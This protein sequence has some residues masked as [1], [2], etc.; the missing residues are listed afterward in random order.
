M[1]LLLLVRFQL[2]SYVPD[3]SGVIS[4]DESGEVT[5]LKEGTATITVKVGDGK[6]YALNS[7]DVMVTVSKIPTEIIVQNVTVDLKVL[8]EVAAGVTLTPADAGNVTYT[9][10]NSNVVIVEDGKIKALI[11]GDAVITVSFAGDKKYAAAENKTISVTVSL[12]EASVS[13]NNS[14]LD[15]FVDDNFTIAYVPDNSGVISVDESGEVTALKEG[16]ATIT[17]KVGGD[18]IYAE[19]S[20]AISVTVNKQDANVNVS[21]PAN[22]TVGDN[23]TVSVKLPSDA[24]GNV[25]VKVDGEVVDTVAVTDGTADVTIPSLSA[26]NHTV[27]IAY[28][29]DGKYNPS[30]ET[31]EIAVSKKETTPDITIPSD[32]TVGDDSNIEIKLPSD[33]IG[34]VTLKV[35][36]EVVDAVPVTDGAANLTIP[37]LKAGNHTVEISYSGD[38][39]YNS[40]SETKDITVSKKDATPEV[41][42]DGSNV[43]VKLPGDATGNVTVKVDDTVVS[44]VPVTDGTASVKLPKLSAGNHTRNCLLW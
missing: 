15:L 2:K 9:S 23:S 6:V 13:V 26:G 17:V 3:N 18:G 16:T 12:K 33:A 38:D 34:N 19:N 11:E 31:K 32:I 41:D 44:T 43:D 5:A 29:G 10:S 14:T 20:T 37:S 40:V 24:T 35:D 25:T 7:T 22:V 8:D 27:E 42:V 39:K 28:S 30:N 4:V 1:L 21:M 36:G